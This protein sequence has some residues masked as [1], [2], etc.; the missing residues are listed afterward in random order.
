MLNNIAITNMSTNYGEVIKLH[1]HEHPF[2][3][4]TGNRLLLHSTVGKLW[5]VSKIY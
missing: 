5:L 1:T 4:K 2:D 3:Q